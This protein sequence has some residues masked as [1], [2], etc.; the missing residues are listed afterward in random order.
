MKN[1]RLGAGSAMWG[2][3]LDPALDLAT[4]GDIQYLGFDFLAELTMSILHRIKQRDP[5][6]GYASDVVP[7]I[8]QLLPVT[9]ARGITIVTNG[10]GANSSAAGDAVIADAA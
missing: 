10:G 3:A 5:S 7:W 9:R 8:S 2:D 6:K 4:R 1:V